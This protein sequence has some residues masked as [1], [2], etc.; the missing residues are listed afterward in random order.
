MQILKEGKSKYFLIFLA[1]LLA[2]INYIFIVKA[3][4][5][6]A[7]LTSF[8]VFLSSIKSLFKENS[9]DSL[10]LI[11]LI[12][13]IVVITFAT[14]LLILTV[15]KKAKSLGINNQQ[16]AKL[17]IYQKRGFYIDKK[18]PSLG[19][20]YGLFPAGASLYLKHFIFGIISILTYPL[21]IFWEIFIGYFG[22]LQENYF[23]TAKFVNESYALEEKKL[24]NLLL[25]M[26]D[27]GKSYIVAKKE[28]DKKYFNILTQNSVE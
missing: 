1:Y 17:K 4:S 15:F 24:N 27:N 20:F 28:L 21:S 3:I 18:K 9:T 23:A 10:K 25:E 19:I 13:A 12:N 6:S 8:N 14:L 2:F 11:F 16:L 5:S 22:S 7:E 26:Q